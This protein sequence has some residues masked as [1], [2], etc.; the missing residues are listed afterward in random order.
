M[1]DTAPSSSHGEHREACQAREREK[2]S[3]TSPDKLAMAIRKDKEISKVGPR[4]SSKKPSG[5]WGLAQGDPE[6]YC[7]A[8]FL[9]SAMARLS[10]GGEGKKSG[11]RRATR[12]GVLIPNW[13]DLYCPVDPLS[14]CECLDMMADE[15]ERMQVE[16]LQPDE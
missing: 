14:A 5:V 9:A 2:L 11:S 7:H 13:L 15:K 8:N 6:H 12:G 10:E 3:L 4:C 16:E 1:T